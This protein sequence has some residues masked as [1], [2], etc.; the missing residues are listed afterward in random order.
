MGVDDER[1]PAIVTIHIYIYTKHTHC[2]LMYIDF[3]LVNTAAIIQRLLEMIGRGP[4]IFAPQTE[5]IIVISRREWRHALF[6][7]QEALKMRFQFSPS[8]RPAGTRQSSPGAGRN[9]LHI[10]QVSK[11]DHTSGVHSFTHPLAHTQTKS[12]PRY[13]SLIRHFYQDQSACLSHVAPPCPI[14]VV[15][16]TYN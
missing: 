7:G 8:W 13:L 12:P 1:F 2:L 14:R 11:G 6:G 4:L 15:S 10:E 3:L 5:K 16:C 9:L